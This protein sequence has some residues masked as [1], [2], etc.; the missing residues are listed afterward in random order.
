MNK[1]KLITLIS[2]ICLTLV[3]SLFVML[4]SNMLMDDLFNK[5]VALSN[6]TIFVTLPA[7]GVAVMFILG[8]LWFIRTYRHP[9][10]VKRISRLYLILAMIFSF[11][12][13][14]GAILGGTVTY[15][16]FTTRNPFPGYLIIFMIVN[17]L[18]LL[19]SCYLLFFKVKKMEE[20]KERIKITFKYVMKTIGWVLF[21]GLA[22]N[23]L[24]MLLTSPVYI[25]TRNLYYTFP[26]YLYL[27]VPVFL[28]TIIV[29]FDLEILN[30]KKTFILGLV[31]IGLNVAFFAY[32]TVKGLGDTSFISSIS[33]L[34]PIDR[35]T[36][37]PIEFMIHFLALLGVGIA[38]IIISKKKTQQ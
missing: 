3:G 21:I 27:L 35:M 2:L 23:R 29:L 22:L 8:I 36:S 28:G 1:K 38:T 11:I 17:I 19:C 13:I 18:I 33:Q 12:G 25:Y 16:S 26:T 4:A 37:K 10:S 31:A 24:G 14:I 5:G 20:D 6:M 7:I 15:G 32:T 30:K 9:N 34:Y